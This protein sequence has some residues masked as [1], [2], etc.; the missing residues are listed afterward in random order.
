MKK[1]WWVFFG[2]CSLVFGIVLFCVVF[3]GYSSLLRS[4]NR[5]A[6]AFD[7]TLVQLRNHYDLNRKLLHLIQ[8]GTRGTEVEARAEELL[9]VLKQVDTLSSARHPLTPEDEATFVQVCTT[10]D[11]QLDQLSTMELPRDL[12]PPQQLLPRTLEAQKAQLNR[13]LLQTTVRYNKEATYFNQRSQVIP[14]RYIARIFS[15]D[16]LNYPLLPLDSLR[17]QADRG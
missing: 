7:L 10:L 13:G 8:T 4:Q 15:L 5:I 1:Q 12:P 3:G 6:A 14:V 11:R 16:Q 9:Q 2:M 17:Q